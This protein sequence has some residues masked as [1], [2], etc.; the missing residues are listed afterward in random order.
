MSPTSNRPKEGRGRTRAARLASLDAPDDFHKDDDNGVRRRLRQDTG[1]KHDGPLRRQDGYRHRFGSGIGRASARLLAA[2]G[3]QVVVADVNLAGAEETVS[4]IA[5]EGGTAPAQWVDVAEEDAIAAMV[6]AAVEHF[7]GL[8]LLHNNAADVSIIF[9]TSM[10]PPWRPR[11]GPHHGGQPPGSDARDQTRAAHLLAAG[12]GAIVTTSS[13]SGQ[14]GDLSRVAYGVSKGGIDSLTRY[15]ATM[16]GK[17]GIRANAVAP[18]VVNTPA[19]AANVPPAEMALYADNH[20]TPGLGEP[21]DIARVVAFLLSDDAAFIT[22]QVVNVDGGMIMHTP[23]YAPQIAAARERAEASHCRSLTPGQARP[24][25]RSNLTVELRSALHQQGRGDQRQSV[26]GQ[27]EV[28][29]LH[30]VRPILE[31]GGPECVH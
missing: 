2:G 27:L 20:V 17:Q 29:D 11:C 24:A 7:G 22:G 1:G 9:G 14:M 8:Q 16:Y 23:L 28:A 10:S 26:R 3:A 4:M 15:V 19:L 12:G 21:D 18:G 13:A 25:I 6:A 30:R 5:D 31:G